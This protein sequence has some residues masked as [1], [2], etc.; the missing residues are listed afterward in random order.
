MDKWTLLGNNVD[1]SLSPLIHNYLIK[2]YE[3]GANYDVTN[4]HNITKQVL[5]GF[6][7]GNITIPHKRAAYNIAGYSNF[8]DQSVNSFKYVNGNLEFMSTD[9]F[10]IIDSIEKLHLKYIHTRLH[11]IFG[12]GATSSMIVG[13]LRN[14][15]KVPSEKIYIISRKDFNLKA[16]PRIIDYNF[17]KKNIKSNYVLY[18]TTPLGNGK[19]SDISPFANDELA[20]ALAIFD[21]SYNPTYNCLAKLAYTNRIR[22]INGL[23]MLI[24]QALHSFEFWT[25]IDVMHEY[26]NIKRRVLAD[27]SSKIIVCAM[28]FAGKSTLYKRNRNRACDLD[29][30]VEKYTNMKNSDF[31]KTY[32]IDKFRAVESKVL[33]TVLKRS[34]IKVV[35]LGG[36]TLTSDAAI[37]ALNDELII[38]MQV[39]LNTL[40]KRF[41]KSR[42]N[43]Q[44]VDYLEQLYYERDHHYRN[45][46]QFQVGS[47][48]IER[49]INEYMGN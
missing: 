26:G 22:Y 7:C 15:F 48:S 42:A 11:I 41:D 18:N 33:K 20:K 5:A 10:G 14:Y 37:N 28:P 40:K 13:C 45:I 31:I 35:F 24:V 6:K 3:L 23:N 21:T 38:Y 12:D 25:D 1:Y 34:E 16:D 9:Q 8:S 39:N 30:E 29:S 36:G 49:M 4:T 47:R 17:F 43:I 32:G 2:K 19:M 44:S 46:S 27:S